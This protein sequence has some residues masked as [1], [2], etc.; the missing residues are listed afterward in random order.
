MI[1]WV[2]FFLLVILFFLS[3]TLQLTNTLK[4]NSLFSPKTSHYVQL[5]IILVLCVITSMQFYVKIQE[6]MTA[7]TNEDSAELDD[8]MFATDYSIS[9]EGIDSSTTPITAP[10][11]TP[12]PYT[13]ESTTQ[14]LNSPNASNLSNM[15]KQQLTEYLNKLYDNGASGTEYVDAPSG[16]PGQVSIDAIYNEIQENAASKDSSSPANFDPSLA[17][18]DSTTDSLYNKK[19]GGLGYLPDYGTLMLANNIEMQPKNINETDN[20]PG[21]FCEYYKNSPMLIENQCT[22]L[23][24]NV[25]A[26]TQCCT[27][28]NGENGTKCVAGNEYGPTNRSYYSNTML[29]DIDYYYYKGNCYGDCPPSS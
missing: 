8:N 10:S 17:L 15:T 4:W 28:L 11:T 29:G 3:I 7:A 21:G 20:L 27:L 5:F 26:S 25:C 1:F 23:D 12:A 22:K 6:G 14:L 18:L 16:A 24:D 13:Y 9:P 2:V 19:E